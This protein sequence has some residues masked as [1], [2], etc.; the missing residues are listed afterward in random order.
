MK[1]CSKCRV[2]KDLIEFGKDNSTKD[3][4]CCYCKLCSK[5]K[6]KIAR[7]KNPEAYKL[8]RNKWKMNNPDKV[9]VMKRNHRIKNKEKYAISNKKYQYVIIKKHL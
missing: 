3:K 7:E 4:L 2:S 1:I 8:A 9:K 6:R 5:E